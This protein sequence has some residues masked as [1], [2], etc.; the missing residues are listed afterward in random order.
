MVMSLPEYP[1]LIWPK[2]L[3]SA[4]FRSQGVEPTDISNIFI[5][6]A[7][8]GRLMWTLRWKRRLI[9]ASSCHG[10]F[11]APSIS[12][13]LVSLPTPSIWTSSSV[14]ILR[15]ASDSPSPLG[16]QRASTSSMKII[17][18]LFSRAMLKSC[19][20]SLD[21]DFSCWINSPFD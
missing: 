14:F 20:T 10:I 19:F 3:K 12:T 6:P 8:S 1:S 21:Y 7:R 2:V 11:V 9:A 5:R 15:D 18:G 17:E 16:P 4:G 13:P